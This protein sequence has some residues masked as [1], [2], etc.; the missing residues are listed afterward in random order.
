M[1]NIFPSDYFHAKVFYNV[2]AFMVNGLM[3]CAIYNVSNAWSRTAIIAG[4][5]YNVLYNIHT[6]IPKLY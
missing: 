4:I 1:L 2:S 3:L 5:N 6:I